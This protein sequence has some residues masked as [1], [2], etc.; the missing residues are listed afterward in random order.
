MGVKSGQDRHSV[1]LLHCLRSTSSFAVYHHP[2]MPNFG[3]NSGHISPG[4]K[5]RSPLLRSALLQPISVR[6]RDAVLLLLRSPSSHPVTPTLNSRCASPS[7]VSY[8]TP[9]FHRTARTRSINFLPNSWIFMSLFRPVSADACCLL[10]LLLSSPLVMSEV[11][12][13]FSSHISQAV[14]VREHCWHRV[15][16]HFSLSDIRRTYFPSC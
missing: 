7:F 1:H 15:A 9:C 6:S 8:A 11:P 2:F 4:M 16:P 3:V 5:I 10:L 13:H 12:S 14:S